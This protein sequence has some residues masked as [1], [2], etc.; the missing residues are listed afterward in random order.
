MEVEVTPSYLV[1]KYKNDLVG[2]AKGP[3]CWMTLP[4]RERSLEVDVCDA[5][6]DP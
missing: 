6:N 5:S 1:T 2:E 3:W 4:S